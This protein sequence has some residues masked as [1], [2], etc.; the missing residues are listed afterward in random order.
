MFVSE[1]SVPATERCA[2]YS[3]FIKFYSS[4]FI[5]VSIY[6]SYLHNICN[7][8]FFILYQIIKTSSF[9]CY[10]TF[11][12]YSVQYFS[13]YTGAQYGTIDANGF[14]QI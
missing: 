11:C 9:K 6:Y 5:S 4:R 1:T 10:R 7:P 3:T 12:R 13:Y 8:L 2:L 14:K